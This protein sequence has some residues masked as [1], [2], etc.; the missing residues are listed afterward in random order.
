[1]KVSLNM[2]ATSKP[3]KCVVS[4]LVGGI[5][6]LSMAAGTNAQEVFRWVDKNG[7]VHYGDMPP[8]PAEVKTVQTKRLSDSVIE[9]D[10]VPFA[11]TTAMKNNPVTL[12]A[13]NCGEACSNAKSLL[14]KRGIPFAEKNP[15]ADP[16]AAAALKE[17]VGALRVPTIV[18]GAN[19][20][21]GF[22]E[23]GWHSA[24]NAAGYPRNNPNLRQ[25]ATKAGPKVPTPAASAPAK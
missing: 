1:M 11:V 15:E 25:G 21:T 3:A 16:A 10:D 20:L 5:L 13:N 22:D 2:F 18:I 6:L 12:Y 17:K 23:E 14:A 4:G 9:Q 7:K 19:S 8:P 24:L